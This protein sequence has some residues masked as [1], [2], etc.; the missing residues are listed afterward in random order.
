MLLTIVPELVKETEFCHMPKSFDLLQHCFCGSFLSEGVNGS[1]T[2]TLTGTDSATVTEVILV[3]SSGSGQV[4][5]SVEVQGGGDF[6]AHFDMIPSEDFVVLVK[7]QNVNSSTRV[8]PVIFQR[9]S[10]TSIRA[11][12]L[13]VTA[14]RQMNPSERL[15]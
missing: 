10:P 7:G 15:I 8:S 11:S 2:V 4:N 1:L 5:G 14:V 3:K 9:Q 12:T 13:S 6:L